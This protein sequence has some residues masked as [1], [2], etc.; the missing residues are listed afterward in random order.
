MKISPDGTRLA[1]AIHG[2]DL[3]E[4]FNF[5]SSTGKVTDVITS[6]ATFD[7]SYGIEF[8]PDSRYLFATT[9]SSSMPSPVYTPPSY[10]FQFDVSR[11]DEMFSQGFYD[12]IASDTTGSY[13]GGIQLATDGKIYVSRAPYGDSSLSVIQNPKRQGLACNFNSEAIYLQGRTCR[14]GFPNFIQIRVFGF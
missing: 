5:N 6:A 1:V 9:T 8:S 14:F 7:E 4:I 3:Y 13:L 11:G 2:S 10:L 12:T